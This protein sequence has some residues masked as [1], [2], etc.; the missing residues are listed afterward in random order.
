MKV[1]MSNTFS[2]I[3]QLTYY[4]SNILS[5]AVSNEFHSFIDV[6]TAF[7]LMNT[8]LLT[9]KIN[10]HKAIEIL[11]LERISPRENLAKIILYEK[12]SC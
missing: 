12:Q 5:D 1:K 6:D 3:N 2:F 8:C 10:P 11:S 4:L 9:A 7:P